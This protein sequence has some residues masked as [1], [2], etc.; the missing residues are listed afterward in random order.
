MMKDRVDILLSVYN[1]NIE[2]LKKQLQSLNEQT[3]DNLKLYIFDDCIENRCDVDIF[4]KYITNFEYEILPYE[5]KN[6]GYIKAF[7]KLI[8]YSN[9]DYIAFCDQDDIWMSNKIERCVEVLKQDGSLAVASERQIIDENDNIV[10]E[11]VRDHSHKNYDSWHSFD[12]IAKYNLF[13]TFAV[14][15]SIVACG[16]FARS[17]LPISPYTAHDKWIL[18]CAAT[19]GTVSFIEEPLVQ[20]RRH[21][22]NVSGILKG[23]NTKKDYIEQRLEP[24]IKAVAAFKEKYPHH[25]DIK[26]MELFAN[27]GKNGNIITL[28]KYR[29][30]APDVAKFNIVFTIVPNFLFKYMLKVA[31]KYG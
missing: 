1:P 11:K 12:D 9:G 26:E 22:K 4:K 14:G 8:Q 31:R 23:I 24:Q 16:D 15:M 13:I 19:E 7:E 10:W 30:L 18:S 21:G 20:Y 29:K 3:Y 6:H 27:A 25:K 2:Y 5:N 17:T 28:F